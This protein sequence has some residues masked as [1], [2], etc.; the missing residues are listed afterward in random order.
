MVVTVTML[1]YAMCSIFYVAIT[2]SFLGVSYATRL[3]R[4]FLTR[5]M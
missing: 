5:Y 3:V 1:A 2:Q 4:L